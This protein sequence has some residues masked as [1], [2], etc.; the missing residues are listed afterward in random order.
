LIGPAVNLARLTTDA[1]PEAKRFSFW[2]DA[3]CNSFAHVDCFR[4]SDRPFTGEIATAR[5]KGIQFSCVRGSAHRAVRT[6]RQI[7]RYSEEVVFIN[8]QTRGTWWS[9]Q[10]GREAILE[11]GDFA[12]FDS[13]RPFEGVQRE[14]FEQIVLQVPR[15]LWLRRIGHTEPLTGRAVRADTPIGGMVSNALRQ[16]MP[17]AEHADEATVHRLMELSLALLATACGELLSPRT[18]DHSTGRL[19]LVCRAKAVIE[20]HLHV[21][22][23][24]PEMIADAL[25][26]S[27]RYLQELFR[28][29]DL[30]LSRWIWSRRL[31]RCRQDLAD[32]LLAGKSISQIAFSWGFSDFSHFS[33][34]FKA[35]FSVSPSEFRRHQCRT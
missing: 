17:I 6:P 7:R 9:S 35:D 15:D 27:V 8:L 16:I 29:E 1:L 11:P 2:R 21:P 3:V 30:T 24:N 18:A 4:L 31:E 28:E 10:D 34:R 12:Y 13:T 32:P 25:K 20:E 19:A 26:I 14:P 22:G 5:V 33:H 23:L